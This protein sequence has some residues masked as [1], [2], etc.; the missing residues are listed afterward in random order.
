MK[1]E[2]VT[3]LDKKNKTTSKKFSDSVMSES[4]DVNAIFPIQD[5]FGEIQKPDFGRIVCKTSLIVTFYLTKTV[6][7]TK[8]L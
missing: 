1:L 3:K 7:R 5:K 2:T 8:N 4:C 6:N